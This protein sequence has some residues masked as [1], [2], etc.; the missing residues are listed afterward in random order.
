MLALNE[1]LRLR[2][3]VEDRINEHAFQNTTLEY[4][5]AIGVGRSC[6]RNLSGSHFCGALGFSYQH[7]VDH[8][9]YQMKVEHYYFIR[10]LGTRF[11]LIGPQLKYGC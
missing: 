11:V 1:N 8:L 2:I 10:P 4:V 7:L 9:P 3:N 6:T 5:P